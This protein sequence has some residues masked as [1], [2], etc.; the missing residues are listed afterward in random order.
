M[1]RAPR[2]AKRLK[3]LPLCGTGA[4]HPYRRDTERGDARAVCCA[5]PRTGCADHHGAAQTDRQCAETACP[6]RRS[7]AT[8]PESMRGMGSWA[9]WLLTA[10]MLHP[11]S[12]A[13]GAHELS[14]APPQNRC[15]AGHRLLPA[16]ADGAI[17]RRPPRCGGP[18]LVARL[19][20]S[21]AW[22]SPRA[23]LRK[24]PARSASARWPR[25][26]PG[27]AGA[28]AFLQKAA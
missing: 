9:G 17:S 5:D 8:G 22:K 21:F 11:G 20:A 28:P 14:A 25:R 10:A 16:R 26:P 18:V 19:Q 15:A 1:L 27:C 6:L 13:L 4:G 2:A 23:A 3:T 7:R 24:V 12:D